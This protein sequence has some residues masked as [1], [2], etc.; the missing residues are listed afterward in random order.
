MGVVP[1]RARPLF[2][3]APTLPRAP[4]GPVRDSGG[5]KPAQT[6]TRR[7][8][9]SC[10]TGLANGLSPKVCGER[11]VRGGQKGDGHPH[12]LLAR[13]LDPSHGRGRGPPYLWARIG[14]AAARQTQGG[15]AAL[16]TRSAP[17]RSD[18]FKLESPMTSHCRSRF[19]STPISNDVATHTPPLGPLGARRRRRWQLAAQPSKAAA[20]HSR[21]GWPTIPVATPHPR[22]SRVPDT[23]ERRGPC[24]FSHV[25]VEYRPHA[26]SVADRTAE[27][28]RGGHRG[29]LIRSR[30]SARV[31]ED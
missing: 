1:G 19:A 28:R 10:R 31:A 22:S 30:P 26:P 27:R 8:L 12:P 18:T 3:P 17:E 29:R 24:F 16:E 23:V 15:A 9:G 5:V 14:R 20:C 6:S 7:V 11:G 2:W 25:G 21:S 4:T 13:R